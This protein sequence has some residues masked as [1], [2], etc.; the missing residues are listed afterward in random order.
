MRGASMVSLREPRLRA[1]RFLS[2]VPNTRKQGE[3]LSCF[4]FAGTRRFRPR[5]TRLGA[6]ATPGL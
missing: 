6:S 2:V 3:A 1:D 5:P 4:S